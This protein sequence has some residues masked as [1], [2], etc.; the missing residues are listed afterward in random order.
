MWLTLGM[1]RRYDLYR[2]T[3]AI[4][5]TVRAIDGTRVRGSRNAEAQSDGIGAARLLFVL[6][7]ASLDQGHRIVRVAR[8]LSCW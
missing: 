7:S 2:R 5:E 3:A 8:V 6:S 4:V 1:R